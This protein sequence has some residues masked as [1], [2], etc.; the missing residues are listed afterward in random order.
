VSGQ[1]VRTKPRGDLRR[2]FGPSRFDAVRERVG[3]QTRNPALTK[4]LEHVA[5]AG[6]NAAAKCNA[7]HGRDGL[8]AHPALQLAAASVFFNSMTIVSGPTPPGTGDSAPA[9]SATSGCTSPTVSD[10][11]LRNVSWR[12]DPGGYIRSTVSR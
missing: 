2:R 9:T 5:L 4:P 6:R 1:D 7:R 10:P 3:I 8:P 12:F 11:R